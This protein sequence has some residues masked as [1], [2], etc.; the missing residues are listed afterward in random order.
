MCSCCV[1]ACTVNSALRDRHGIGAADQER[2]V[3]LVEIAF[4][5]AGK[6][7][8][9]RIAGGGRNGKIDGLR[10]GLVVGEGWRNIDSLV[11]DCGADRADGEGGA[12]DGVQGNGK[13]AARNGRESIGFCI[14]PKAGAKGDGFVEVFQ[15]AFGPDA[16]ERCDDRARF[17]QERN[18]FFRDETD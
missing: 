16:M 4:G 8:R 7:E 5:G 10:D 18:R 1:P 9:F 3:D 6:P 11:R 14:E 2:V 13:L 12:I 15:F 17:E